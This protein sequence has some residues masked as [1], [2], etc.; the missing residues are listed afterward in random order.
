MGGMAR[1]FGYLAAMVLVSASGAGLAGEFHVRP[2]LA[3]AS[4]ASGFHALSGAEITARLAGNT[5]AGVEDGEN[6][7]EYLSPTGTLF[8]RAESGRYLGAWRV[9][10]NKFCFRYEPEAEEGKNAQVGVWECHP[11]TLNGQSIYWS[12]DADA[13]DPVEATLLSGNA[14]QL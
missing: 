4:S 2:K 14:K 9:E 1:V 12:E 3:R 5:V 13:S 6:Y 8:G 10:G 7:V 11:V